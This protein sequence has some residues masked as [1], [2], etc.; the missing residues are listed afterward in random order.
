[1]FYTYLNRH[2]VIS[3]YFEK[4]VDIR[5]IANVAGHNSINTTLRYIHIHVSHSIQQVIKKVLEPEEFSEEQKN[6]YQDE[7]DNLKAKLNDV[8]DTL[9]VIK[10]NKGVV[11]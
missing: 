7:I 3:R 8:L 6:K 2:S 1:M 5:D 10:S 11:T 4:G 9:R